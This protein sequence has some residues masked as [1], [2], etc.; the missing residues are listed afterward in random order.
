[1]LV[2][3][4]WGMGGERAIGAHTTHRA[5]PAHWAPVKESWEGGGE[6]ALGVCAAP[7]KETRGGRGEGV[8]GN[9]WSSK[10]A[11]LF[12][13]A[14]LASFARKYTCTWK[15]CNAFDIVGDADANALTTT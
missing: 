14:P 6:C 11:F 3:E 8:A 2:N 5:P 13:E 9:W 12:C 1:M 10:I 7:T 15:R 4:G